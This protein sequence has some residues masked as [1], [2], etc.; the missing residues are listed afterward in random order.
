MMISPEM[1]VEEHNND[2]FEKLIEERDELIQIIKELE[3]I[4]FDESKDDPAWQFR[5]GPDVRYQMNL[6]YLSA[7][8]KYIKDKY[9]KEIVWG[10]TEEDE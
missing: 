4:V 3:T 7:L 9:N 5:P 10:E 2:S 6:E 1:Y 8:C